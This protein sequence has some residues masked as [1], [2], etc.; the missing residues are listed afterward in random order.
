VACALCEQ[1]K[2]KRTCPAVA[3]RI[4]AP[5]CGEQREVKLDCPAT[6]DYLIE[7]RR[8]E[9][10]RTPAELAGEEVFDNIEI[11]QHF[12]YEFEPLVGGL[13]FSV[14]RVALAEA[15]WHD[16]DAI[17]ALVAIGKDYQR[18]SSSG[19]VY[20]E[21]AAGPLQQ[22]LAAE[23]ERTIAEYK[24]VQTQHLGFERLSDSDILEALVVV[25]RTALIRTNGRPRSRAFLHGLAMQ[26]PAA[27]PA[28]PASG[29]I[30]P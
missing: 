29:I 7:A 1:R 21:F 15:R 20:E 16:R 17:D 27:Q 8:H 28:Q 5:C 6:C 25:V 19:L 13:I 26:F 10:P 3:A 22:R 4:C 23:I 14:A 30:V 18:R 24:R 12:F 2:E 11:P 9:K